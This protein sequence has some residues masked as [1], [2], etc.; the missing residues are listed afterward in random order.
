MRG[1]NTITESC[2][3]GT[4]GSVIALATRLKFAYISSSDE[5][6]KD[7]HVENSLEREILNSYAHIMCIT[8]HLFD[9]NKTAKCT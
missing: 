5:S 6:F 8:Y 3:L 1:K 4:A 9:L 7:G 2:V